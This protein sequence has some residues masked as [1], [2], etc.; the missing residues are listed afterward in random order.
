MIAEKTTKRKRVRPAEAR[1]ETRAQESE[2]IIY[3]AK[4]NENVELGHSGSR[5]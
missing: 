4:S 2:K 3:N 5:H 1:L